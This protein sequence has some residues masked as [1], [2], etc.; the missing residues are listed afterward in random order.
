MRHPANWDAIT[1]RHLVPI[2]KFI[3]IPSRIIR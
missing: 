3:E 1:Y 2:P